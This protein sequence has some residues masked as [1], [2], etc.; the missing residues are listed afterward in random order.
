MNGN[1]NPH[2]TG[3][4]IG[5]GTNHLTN[6]A[7]NM[8]SFKSNKNTVSSNQNSNAANINISNQNDKSNQEVGISR[9]FSVNRAFGKDITN[10][11]LNSSGAVSL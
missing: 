2:R 9:S 11:I 6:V 10:K 7:M 1:S 4:L 3:S 5:A 8:M